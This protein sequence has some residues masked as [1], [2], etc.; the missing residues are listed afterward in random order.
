M[1]KKS[2]TIVFFGSGPVAAES[3]KQLA[4]HF[5]I[6]A[7][8]TKPRPAHHK[9]S[10]PVIEATEQLDLSCFTAS[11]KQELHEVVQTQQFKS[12]VGVLIDFAIIVEAQTMKLFKK[13]IVNS[14]FSLLP[15]WRGPDPITFA[16]L[17]GQEYSGTSLML[18]APGVDEGPLLAQARYDMSPTI[19][20]PELTKELID[21]ST[22]LLV[23]TLPLYL[24][25]QVSPAPQES[26]SI[27]PTKIPSYSRK[28][29][30]EDG[31]INWQKP[32]AVLDREV[33]A[34][35]G[36]PGS[37]T[38]LFGKEV[39]IT[40][41]KATKNDAKPGSILHDKKRL[42]VGTSKGSLEIRRLKP[43]GKNEMPAA[44]FLAGIKH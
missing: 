27:A 33:R 5:V 28:L 4:E 8:I 34:Y 1:T 38:M 25:D 39:I 7:V 9:G 35:C 23:E 29:T 41:A 37:R 21:L 12:K 26:A 20:T 17:S 42:I 6:E 13:G 30:K 18:L 3:L 19:T 16:V 36:W 15:Q 14:H 24:T 11:N 31:L 10:V 40:E 2:K 32:A 22:T 44:A 43:A